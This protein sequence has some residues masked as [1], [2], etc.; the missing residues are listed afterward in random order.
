MAHPLRLDVD[1]QNIEPI[2]LPE[3][4]PTF[5]EKVKR[6]VLGGEKNL[7]DRN[8]FHSM[9]LLPFFAWVGLGA[10]GLSSSSYGPQEAWHI[11]GNYPALG[12]LVALMATITVFVLSASYVQIIELF[13]GGGGGYLVASKLL[14]P[15]LG[16]VSG[17]ALVIDYVLTISISIAAGADAIFSFLPAGMIAWK[18]HAIIG[19]ILLLTILN[20]RGVRES[21]NFMVPI[22]LVFVLT[23]AFG[24]VYSIATHVDDAPAIAARAASDAQGA[25]ATLGLIGAFL[26]VTK[27]F[28]LGAGTF[29]GIEAVSNGLNILREPRVRNGKRTMTYMSWSLAITV[30]GLFLAYLIY[31]VH[32]GEHEVKTL[33]AI[34][35]EAMTRDW[36]KGGEVFVWVTLFS[37]AAILFIASQAGFIGGPRVL[38]NMALDRWIPSRFAGLSDRLVTQ[39]GVLL[40]AAIALGTVIFTGGSVAKLVVLYS[41]NVFVTFA[42]SMGGL[43]RHW[44]KNK[45]RE[46][47]WK[48]KIWVPMV[49]LVI[50]MF[51]LV[52][53][54]VEKFWEG[55][56]AAVGVTAVLVAIS[57]FVKRHYRHT[58]SLLKRLDQLVRTADI[59]NS[60]EKEVDIPCDPKAK[61]A[62]LLVNGYN[63]LGLHTLL[64][65]QRM[66]SGVY[67]NWIFVYVGVVDAGNFKGTEE[68]DALQVHVKEEAEKYVR[69]MRRHGAYSEAR[70]AV[71]TDVASEMMELTPALVKAFPQSTFFGGQLVF[72][73]DSM[74]TRF[75]HNNIVFGIQRKFYNLGIPFV[76]LPVRV[77]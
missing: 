3:T 31:Q 57:F 62:V 4:K 30:I 38:A 35:F 12:L 8:I 77:Y 43:I 51:I 44:W 25:V 76:I 40:M 74:F 73:E 34:L 18:F 65:I 39:N 50:S 67:K 64:N 20:M 46:I 28:C 70:T 7:F 17:C 24:I 23:H 33:N 48:R 66:F 15:T 71:G 60:A 9:A 52:F 1:E 6:I 37:E 59:S 55:G 14:N 36:G 26:L 5:F 47:E 27:A 42:L 58:K 2:P 56:L 13:P 61:T 16:M 22:F 11:L 63:G 68:M 10:D 21:V 49:G 69:F 45:G 53:V 75:L 29:T 54:F 32:R 19:G 41:I 72:P